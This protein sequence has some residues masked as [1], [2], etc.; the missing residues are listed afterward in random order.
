MADI[1]PADGLVVEID[2]DGEA[3]APAPA[4]AGAELPALA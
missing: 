4:G 3:A 2:E 1:A